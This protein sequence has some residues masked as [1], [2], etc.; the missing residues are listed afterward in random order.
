MWVFIFNQRSTEFQGVN[1]VGLTAGAEC[2][3]VLV[4][5][6]EPSLCDHLCLCQQPQLQPVPLPH[7]PQRLLG[8][9]LQETLQL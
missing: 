7:R 8:G 4:S 3:P 5:P 9:C 6:A 2:A 1:E